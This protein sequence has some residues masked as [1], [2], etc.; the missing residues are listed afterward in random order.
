MDKIETD[1]IWVILKKSARRFSSLWQV[2]FA[3]NHHVGDVTI[4]LS[5]NEFHTT[6]HSLHTLKWRDTARL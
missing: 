3:Q 2:A 6:F 5:E 1:C 4:I